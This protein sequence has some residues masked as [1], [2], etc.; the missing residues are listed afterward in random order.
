MIGWGAR[1]PTQNLYSPKAVRE[2]VS[3]RQSCRSSANV[4][5]GEQPDDYAE[6]DQA[7]DAI[8]S[9]LFDQLDDIG[10]HLAEERHIGT[11]QERQG[12]AEREQHQRD[13]RQSADPRFQRIQAIHE[14]SPLGSRYARRGG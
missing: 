10:G 8:R 2:S 4:A 6:S 7:D 11:R 5:L 13:F 3:F 9:E 12:N 1:L 14:S